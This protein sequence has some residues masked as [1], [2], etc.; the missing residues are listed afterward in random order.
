MSQDEDEVI[1]SKEAMKFPIVASISLLTQYVLINA[2]KKEYI[3]TLLNLYICTS[4]T[5][6]I[7]EYQTDLQKTYLYN[8]K[9]ISEESGDTLIYK[10]DFKLNFYFDTLDV[11]FD[12]TKCSLVAYLVGLMVCVWFMVS[13]NWMANNI[14]GVS[15]SVGAIML[16]KVKDFKTGLIILWGLFLYDIFWVFKTDVMVSVAKGLDSPIKL[17]FPKDNTLEQFSILGLG[18][19]IVPGMYVVLCLKYDV[20]RY[21]KKNLPLNQEK[22]TT[23]YFSSSLLGYFLS[24]VTTF[25]FMIAFNHA[26]PA[27]LYIVPGLTIFTVL[28]ALKYKKIDEFFAYD[29]AQDEYKE[30]KKDEKEVTRDG[31]VKNENNTD[32]GESKPLAEK[33]LD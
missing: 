30:P 14:I 9:D 1:N 4:A 27:L 17:K 28:P 29:S 2:V 32:S 16:I 33:K 5:I 19:I 7:G 31:E 8:H 12:L 22:L 18:D 25:I 3:S 15:L 26:Q 21:I 13:G 11:K 6:A 24:I 10:F 23:P 20:D